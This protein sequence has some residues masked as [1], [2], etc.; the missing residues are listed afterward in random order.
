MGKGNRIYELYLQKA[1]EK[2]ELMKK[3]KDMTNSAEAEMPAA[4]ATGTV[5]E[6]AEEIYRKY[7][8]IN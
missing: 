6:T 2:W 8:N 7:N 4:D 5:A 3:G 1:M